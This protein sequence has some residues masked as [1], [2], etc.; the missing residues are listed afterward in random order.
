[1]GASS[2]AAASA[3]GKTTIVPQDGA[4][5]AIG[6]VQEVFVDC[7]GPSSECWLPPEPVPPGLD[8]DMWLGPAPWAPFNHGRLTFRPWRDYSG[9]GMTDWGAHNFGGALF[10]CNL[11]ETGPV[12]IIPPNKK[13]NPLLTY[14][15]ANGIVFHHQGGWGGKSVSKAAK[16]KFRRGP[17]AN[18]HA[19]KAASA[20]TTRPTSSSPI[21][22][23]MAA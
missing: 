19:R 9:G 6:T 20:A 2:Q 23:A 17:A 12:E 5:R 10:S 15:F 16:E 8:W 1:M 14:K 21:T 22:K 11:H 7:A 4:R 3:S 18:L 13:D